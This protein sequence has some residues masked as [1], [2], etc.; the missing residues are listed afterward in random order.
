M[1]HRYR[2]IETV[3]HPGGVMG[4]NS[5]MLK[6]PSH[7][8]DVIVMVNRADVSGLLLVNEILDACLTDLAPLRPSVRDPLATGTFRLPRTGRVVQLLVQEERQIVSIDGMDMPVEPDDQGVLWPAGIFQGYTKQG[9]NLLGDRA[10]PTAIVL[11]DFGNIDELI[12]V[13]ADEPENLDPVVG[14]Y[15]AEGVGV[16]ATIHGTN[17]G[18]RLRTNGGFGTAEFRLEYLATGIWRAKSLGKM[19]WGGILSFAADGTR[20]QFF[21]FR[22]WALPFRRIE[23]GRRRV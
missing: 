9:I 8:L 11:D 2:G 1:T 10:H 6:V 19:P 18:A 23:D 22:T 14:H 4:G 7:G 21:T 17:E 5:Q 3:S 16:E 13:A 20:F 12:H 15:R